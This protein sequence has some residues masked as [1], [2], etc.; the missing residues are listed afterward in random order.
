MVAVN[1]EANAPPIIALVTNFAK[2]FL[3]SGAIEP[4]PPSCIPIDAKLAKPH[5]E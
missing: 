5:N 2:S 3:R 1:H 4:I